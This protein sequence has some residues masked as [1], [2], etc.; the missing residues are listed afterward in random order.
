NEH[1][2][3]MF[4][5]HIMELA[6]RSARNDIDGHNTVKLRRAG[7]SVSFDRVS[8]GHGF[9]MRQIPG[10]DGAIVWSTRIDKLVDDPAVRAMLPHLRDPAAAVAAARA[11][12]SANAEYQRLRTFRQQGPD[13]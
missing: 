11:E 3:L 7:K 8:V 12:L 2:R 13:T 4:N 10:D 1:A 6:K 5:E 9:K